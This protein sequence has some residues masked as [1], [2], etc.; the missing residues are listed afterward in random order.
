[1]LLNCDTCMLIRTPPLTREVLFSTVLLHVVR[2]LSDGAVKLIVT[3]TCYIQSLKRERGGEGRGGEGRGGEG[4]GGEGRGGKGEG[5][6]GRG[7]EGREGEGRGG[8]GRGEEGRGEEG[9][10]GEGGA[11]K[12]QK[13][14]RKLVKTVI[15]PPNVYPY[16]RHKP[17]HCL[18]LGDYTSS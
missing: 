5:G 17:S 14:E 8:E 2:Q 1:M 16:N 3:G 13:Q 9:R 10:E 12:E 15:P 4:R 11:N 6:E 7:G 18:R